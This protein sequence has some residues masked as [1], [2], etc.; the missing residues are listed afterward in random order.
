[1]L[2]VKA[3]NVPSDK[4]MTVYPSVVKVSVRCNFPLLDDPFEGL[5]IEADYDDLNRSLSG[6]CELRPAIHARGVISCDIEPVA[7]S[8][9]L[10][11][12]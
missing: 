12:W 2:P 8:C 10:E 1:M 5:T 11:E 9:V 7:V 6:K 3:V 4:V